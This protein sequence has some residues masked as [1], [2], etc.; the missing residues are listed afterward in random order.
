[1]RHAWQWEVIE[2]RIEPPGGWRECAGFAEAHKTYDPH[3]EFKYAHDEL[4]RD[5]RDRAYVIYG[6]REV[7]V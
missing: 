6:F 1:M 4:E 5:A 2:G 7:G 3:D